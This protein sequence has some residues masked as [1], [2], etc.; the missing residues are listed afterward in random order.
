MSVATAIRPL[1]WWD[2]PA[3]RERVTLLAQWSDLHARGAPASAREAFTCKVG[4][5]VPDTNQLFDPPTNAPTRDECAQRC[6]DWPGCVATAQP[7]WKNSRCFLF[8]AGA[9]STAGKGW[10]NIDVCW[11]K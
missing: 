2:I 3:A 6:L 8:G 9:A 11:K 4:A 7:T 5:A 1:R 10:N